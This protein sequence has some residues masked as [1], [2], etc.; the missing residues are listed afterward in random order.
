LYLSTDGKTWTL[1]GSA[2]T[3]S[4]TLPPISSLG[5]FDIGYR[6]P[7]KSKIF[8]QE[9]YIEVDG[10]EV[11]RAATVSSASLTA[12]VLQSTTTPTTD[13]IG[14][15]GQILVDTATG[16]G[17]MCVGFSSG[18]YTWKQITA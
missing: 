6:V 9:T 12:P 7:T 11:W 2:T 16:T 5:T 4:S 15:I 8:L 3:A 14:S 18:S 1:E 13:T 17:Y 10:V